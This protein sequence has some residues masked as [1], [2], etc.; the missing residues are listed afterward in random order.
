MAP[1]QIGTS[2]PGEHWGGRSMIA[3]PWGVVL[4]EAPDE[5]TFAIAN[6]DL[7]RQAEVRNKLPSLAN[8]R[9]DTYRWPETDSTPSSASHRT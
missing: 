9:A 5:E 1:N 6:L 4:A 8:R 2:I 3:D 7:A